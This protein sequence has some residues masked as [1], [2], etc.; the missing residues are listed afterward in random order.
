M[1][2]PLLALKAVHVAGAVL[3][4][5]NV[6]V[7]GFWAAWLYRARDAMQFARTARTIMLADW[8]FTVVGG[9]VLTFTGIQLALREGLD[10]MHTPWIRHGIGALAAATVLWLVLLLPDQRRMER[11]GPEDGERLRRVFLRWRV[12]GWASTL[13]LFY[14]LW[15]MVTRSL[16]ESARSCATPCQCD[17]LKLRNSSTSSA[18]T[19]IARSAGLPSGVRVSA[20]S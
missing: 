14:G 20:S 8:I 13:A 1:V 6:T 17:D 2:N 12:V 10:V 11:L 3:L 18:A 19:H 9:T 4:L 5:G 16:I 15:A 7:T